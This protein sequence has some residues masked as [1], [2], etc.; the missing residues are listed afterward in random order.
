SKE[1]DIRQFFS[2]ISIVRCRL[3]HNRKTNSLTGVC[4]IELENEGDMNKAML[5]QKTVLSIKRTGENRYLELTSF[6][7]NKELL[8]KSKDNNKKPMKA[9][10]PIN[11]AIGETGELFVRN[12]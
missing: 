12:L 11:E 3:I 9:Y 10:E 1:N 5:K 2:P 6:I 8:N 4:W 7:K